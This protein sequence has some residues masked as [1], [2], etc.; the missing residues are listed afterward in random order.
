MIEPPSSMSPNGEVPNIPRRLPPWRD[1]ALT[2]AVVTVTLP[3]IAIAAAWFMMQQLAAV[4]R[5]FFIAVFLAYVLLPYHSRL[6][7]QIG[8]P[9]SIG[10]IASAT[11]LAL[12]GLALAVYA[13][14]LGLSDEPAAPATASD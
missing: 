9:A 12:L 5:P 3:V 2:A 6:R 13:S 10:V 14:V 1:P 4:L 8:A 7:K 11:A